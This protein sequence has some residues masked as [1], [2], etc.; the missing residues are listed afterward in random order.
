M[1][2]ERFFLT[3]ALLTLTTGTTLLAQDKALPCLLSA[4]FESGL[5]AG[6][7]IGAP[8]EVVGGSGATADA[9]RVASASEANSNGFFPVPDLPY[10][11]RFIM[12]NDDAP[13]CDCSM[14]SVV[15]TAPAVD[16]TAVNGAVLQFRVFHDGNFEG[17]PAL[18]EASTD[19]STWTRV[20]SIPS[21]SG[22]WQQRFIDLSAYDGVAGL[23]VRFSWSDNGQ[24]ASGI[25]LDDICVRGRLNEDLTLVEAFLHDPEPSPFNTNVR[26]LRYTELPLQQAEALTVAARIRNSGRNT[27][28]QLRVNVSITQNG[29][30]QGPFSSATLDSL[31][32]GAEVLLRV[33]TGWTPTAVGELQISYTVEAQQ[34]DEDAL[35][36]SAELSM[37]I[38]GPGWADGYGALASFSGTEA[39]G[40]VGE[41]AFVVLAR[42]ELGNEANAPTGVS[43]TFGGGCTVGT[44][45]RGMLLDDNL[46]FVDSSMR[47]TLTAD[48]IQRINDGEPFFLPLGG[49]SVSGDIH[50]GVQ[51]LGTSD[52]MEVRCS[53]PVAPGAAVIM[54]GLFLDVDYA[55]RSP[56]LRLHFEQV[57][58]GIKEEAGSDDA[59]LTFQSG[60]DL[61]VIR[62]DDR[63]TAELT[64][65]DGAG[66]MVSRLGMPPGRD[67]VSIPINQLP[68]GIF[69]VTLTTSEGR[70]AQRVTLVPQR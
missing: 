64:V 54:E 41:G 13:P 24:W 32:P 48:D 18:V 17:G 37:R 58:V 16:L 27:A 61:V 69:V 2:R 19:G 3:A 8:V 57:G 6:W 68:S 11:G 23:Q 4:D 51:S 62:K 7:D 70:H 59:M 44:T 55:V 12:A 45:I 50:Y 40:V 30:T 67:R 10:D 60:N 49:A 52:R 33:P 65:L 15:L 35:D 21:V 28:R 63:S 1:L 38:T 9:W 31:V 66:R 56:L 26:S 5:P 20:D 47:R 34:A 43:V 22:A 36:N 29:D 39:G 14:G 46:S 53:G 42:A 25:A